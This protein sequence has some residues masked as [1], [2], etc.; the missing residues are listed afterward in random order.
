MEYKRKYRQMDDATKQ[1]ISLRLKGRSKSSTTKD[2]ISKSLKAY[3]Q[4][5]P[6]KPTD[7]IKQQ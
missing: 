6:N 7:E 3:W 2:R 5:V 1:K 4:S